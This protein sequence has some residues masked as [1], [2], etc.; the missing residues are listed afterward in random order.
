[1]FQVASKPLAYSG[2]IQPKSSIV[3]NQLSMML[4]HSPMSH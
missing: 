3:P 1:M 4:Q 2:A